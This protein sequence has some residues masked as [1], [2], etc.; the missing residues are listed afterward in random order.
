MALVDRICI[1]LVL[2]FAGLMFI[3]GETGPNP[4]FLDA[5]WWQAYFDIVGVIALKLILPL[6]VVLRIADWITGGPAKR[7]GRF[8]VHRPY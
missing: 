1:I 7:R 6:W 3:L 2:F 4:K 8:T 5:D